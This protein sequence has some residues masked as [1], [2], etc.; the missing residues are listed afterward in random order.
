MHLHHFKIHI[1]QLL[2]LSRCNSSFRHLHQLPK[3]N[4]NY[5]QGFYYLL[6]IV[7]KLSSQGS[8]STYHQEICLLINFLFSSC[9][10]SMMFFKVRS[11]TYLSYFLFSI[12]RANLISA[13]QK[14]CMHSNNSYLLKKSSYIFTLNSYILSFL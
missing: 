2:H 10:D 13:L 5:Y 7:D 8:M 3:R 14:V 4:G 12:C 11:Y 9:I 1:I 6:I